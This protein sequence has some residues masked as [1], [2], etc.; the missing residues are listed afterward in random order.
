MGPN[1][2]RVIRDFYYIIMLDSVWGQIS[3]VLGFSTLDGLN[4]ST[5][6]KKVLVAAETHLLIF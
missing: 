6:P 3:G 1:L 4:S 2:T 5:G